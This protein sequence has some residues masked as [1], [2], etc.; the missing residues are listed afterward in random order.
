MKILVTNQWLKKLGGSETFSYTIIEELIRLGHQVDYLTLH[1]GAMSERIEQLGAYRISLMAYDLIL[2]NHNST[3]RELYIDRVCGPLV[4]TCHG[5][6]SS[7][8]QPSDLAHHHISISKE[9]S[10]HLNV[11][12]FKSEIILNSIN[13][14]R[15]RCQKKP[16]QKIKKVLS[17][18]HNDDLNNSIGAIL[19]KKEIIF[20]TINKYKIQVW[21]IEKEI[22]TADLVISLGRGAYEAMACGRPVLVLDKRPY[23]GAILGDGLIKPSN[24]D[25]IIGNNCSGRRF[26]KTDIIEMLNEALECNPL[27]LGASLRD[28]AEDFLDVRKNILKYLKYA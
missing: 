20:K 15:F 9:V 4:Q 5:I 6:Y 28:Y 1:H 17:F 25:E 24:I 12:G 8:E 16:G 11:S 22:N 23:I 14:E 21:D 27:E 13:L 26:M 7:L 10:D 18:I 19:K 3:I 2:A